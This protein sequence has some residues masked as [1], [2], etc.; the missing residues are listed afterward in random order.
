MLELCDIAVLVNN[1][2]L[3][4]IDCD[5]CL[6]YQVGNELRGEKHVDDE[7]GLEVPVGVIFRLHLLTC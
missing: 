1:L 7:K 5:D 4:F 6:N 3:L 2:A